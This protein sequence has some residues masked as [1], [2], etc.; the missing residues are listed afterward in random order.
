MLDY[1]TSHCSWVLLDAKRSYILREVSGPEMDRKVE[2]E[3]RIIIQSNAKVGSIEVWS[4][5]QMSGSVVPP[6]L[7]HGV[8]KEQE[9]IMSG[10]AVR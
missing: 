10:E 5:M 8:I 4:V 1:S 6:K 2:Q 3:E 9:G 7:M